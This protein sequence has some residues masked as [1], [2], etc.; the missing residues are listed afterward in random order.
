M[1]L[2]RWVVIAVIE[3][4]WN[5]TFEKKFAITVTEVVLIHLLSL[6]AVFKQK[7]KNENMGYHGTFI[8]FKGHLNSKQG[9]PIFSRLTHGV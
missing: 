3:Y 7:T 1:L 2:S 8:S 6:T 5:D 9:S 4:F